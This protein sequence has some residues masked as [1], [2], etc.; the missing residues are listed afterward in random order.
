MLHAVLRTKN[1]IKAFGEDKRGGEFYHTYPE[2]LASIYL[3]LGL[4]ST[5]LNVQ[6]LSFK[7]GQLQ[8]L[9]K[10]GEVGK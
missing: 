9:F 10:S 5:A 7:G 2:E 8:D 1:K 6:P 3:P 4:K